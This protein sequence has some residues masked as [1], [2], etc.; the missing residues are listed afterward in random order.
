MK[1]SAFIK[2]DPARRVLEYNGIREIR[3][4]P[5]RTILAGFVGVALCTAPDP[6]ARQ[7]PSVATMDEKTLAEYAGVYRWTADAFLYLQLWDEFSGFG[8]PRELV[9][10][11]EGGEVR[12]LY[13]TTARDEFFAGPGMAISSSIESRIAF[14][15]DT[16]GRI[17]SLSWRRDGAAPRVATRVSIE[18]QEDVHFA[19]GSLQLAG[20]LI[21][22]QTGGRHPA[23]VLV[24]GSGAEDRRYMWPWARFLVRHGVAILGYDKRG[25]GQSTGNWNDASFE[26]LAGDVVSA[27]EYLKTR[28]D[29]DAAHIGLLGIS[30]AGWIMPLAAVRTKDVAFLISIS[31]AGVSPAETTLDQAR[32]ELSAAGM[33]P[34]NVDAI[35][36][37][38][39]LLYNF[40]RTNQGWDE[41]AAAR[42]MLAAR[43]GPPP[44]T[45]PSTPNDPYFDTIRRFYFYDPGPTLRRLQTPT[46]AIWGELDNNIVAEKNRAAWEVALSASGNRDFTLTILPR[47]DHALW[48]AKVGSN[49]E[50]K[51]LQ[52]FV[53]AYSMTVQAWLAKRV[54]GLH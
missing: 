51:A 2:T 31:G 18:R 52:R 50:M 30:Q 38:Q 39:K 5:W 36:N 7:S 20:T 53:P 17:T 41:Y 44:P 11:D 25:V 15:R 22:P 47:G 24:Y 23:I 16:A 6:S 42:T 33:P 4:A 48:E 13:P 12:T 8:K 46:L 10:F 37:V 1:K 27:V 28:R 3:V 21:S 43:M 49:A 35:L 34:Q 14:Q 29:I 54:P 19:S 9:A 40:A 45:I 32:N 26:D